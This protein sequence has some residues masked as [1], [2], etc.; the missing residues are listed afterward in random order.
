VAEWIRENTPPG[1]VILAHDAP[2]YALLTERRTYTHRFAPGPRLLR[3]YAPD[4]VVFDRRTREGRRFAAFVAGRATRRWSVPS[5]QFDGGIPVFGLG[6]RAED[7]APG[8]GS[9]DPR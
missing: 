1:A 2:L 8:T 5:D 3:R 4:Y 9:Y 7:A 6:R